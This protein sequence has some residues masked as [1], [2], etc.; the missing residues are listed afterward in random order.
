VKSI[1]EI[2]EITGNWD[3]L[4]SRPLKIEVE[5]FMPLHIEVIGSG[6]GKAVL[7]SVMH[8]YVQNG[9][10]MRDPDVE[11]QV[12]PDSGEEWLPVSY[13][14]DGLGVFRQAVSTEGGVVMFHHGLVADLKGFLEMWDRDIR[15]KGYV[16]A[17]RRL[18]PR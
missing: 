13:R 14:Q 2:I 9:D 5:G 15:E 1:E 11:V 4:R 16:E 3:A 12:I 7:L 6:P 8:T 17:A 10:V 18:T